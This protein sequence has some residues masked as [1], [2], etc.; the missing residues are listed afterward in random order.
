MDQW[1]EEKL[2]EVVEKKHGEKERSM[3]Q[4]SIVRCKLPIKQ[5]SVNELFPCTILL[6]FRNLFSADLP[7][8]FGRCRKIKIRVVLGMS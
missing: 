8:F 4:T 5:Y 1:D 6:Q 7:I 2:K 3:P